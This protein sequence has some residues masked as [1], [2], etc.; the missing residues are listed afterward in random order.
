VCPEMNKEL[1]DQ[2]DAFAVLC[3]LLQHA[4]VDVVFLLNF[5]LFGVNIRLRKCPHLTTM[6]AILKCRLKKTT[7]A[8]APMH[9]KV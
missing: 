7:G 9:L 2:V 1:V 4:I 3:V 5:Y 6:H 8:H